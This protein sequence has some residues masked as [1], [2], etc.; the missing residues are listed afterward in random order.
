MVVIG[1]DLWIPWNR[2]TAIFLVI[3]ILRITSM[4]HVYAIRQHGIAQ[5]FHKLEGPQEPIIDDE[6]WLRSATGHCAK[7]CITAYVRCRRD[8]NSLAGPG[9]DAIPFVRRLTV[10]GPTGRGAYMTRAVRRRRHPNAQCNDIRRHVIDWR[11]TRPG[12]AHVTACQHSSQN[13]SPLCCS[14]FTSTPAHRAEPKWR[15]HSVAR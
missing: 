1:S 2:N 4:R 3:G 14:R 5:S 8:N 7:E 13:P 10:G 15:R 6:W 12:D 9:N 11:H